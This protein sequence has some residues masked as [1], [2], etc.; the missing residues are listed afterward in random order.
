MRN[1]VAAGLSSFLVGAAT[2]M[3]QAPEATAPAEPEC[4]AITFDV[5][6]VVEVDRDGDGPS[7][8]TQEQREAKWTATLGPRAFAVQSGDALQTWD[9]AAG[10]VRSIDRV[11]GTYTE[12]SM[13]HEVAF[14]QSEMRNR[15]GIE[16]VLQS[17]SLPIAEEWQPFDLSVLFV[18]VAEGDD[19]KLQHIE[20]DDWVI[21]QRDGDTVARWTFG[22]HRLDAAQSA[23][24][25]RLLQRRAHLHPQTLAALLAGGR[26]PQELE[27][28]W[29]NVG[30]RGTATWRLAEV[31]VDA[32]WPGGI[33]GATRS[34]G[35]GP[36][37][38][39]ASMVMK[40]PP[41]ADVPDR[42]TVADFGELAEAAHAAGRHGDALLL[43]LEGSLTTGEPMPQMAKLAADP[44]AKE[45]M[46]RFMQPISLAGRAP[47]RAL[48]LFAAIDRKELSRPSILDVFRVSALMGKRDPVQARELMLV[49]LEASPWITMAYKD[50]GDIFLSEFDTRQAWIAWELGRR[51]AP[52]H[53]CWEPVAAYEQQLRREFADRL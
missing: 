53:G 42:L 3:A 40:Q 22:E 34:F 49:T 4:L 16:R 45:E 50:L 51:I 32:A 43:L 14:V 15:L 11:A 41:A 23:M 24:F 18:S 20:N 10:V 33:D 12:V 6:S 35:T 25:G 5:L 39:I 1:C 28:H 19:S 38:R 31:R 48:A 52:G 46:K 29:R 30:A 27:F 2:A 8:A 9:F 26:L 13:L 7:P 44:A 47:D 21:S 17:A 37:A 36:L